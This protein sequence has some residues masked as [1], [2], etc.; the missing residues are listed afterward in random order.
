MSA[1][2]VSL[3]VLLLA[4][5]TPAHVWQPPERAEAYLPAIEAAETAHGLPDGLLARLLYEESR[6]RRDVVAGRTISPRGAVGIAQFMPA[7]ADELGVDPRSPICSI[8]AA[9]RYL[10]WL[11]EHTGTW[12]DAL[13]AYNWGIGRVWRHGRADAPRETRRFVRRI[14]EDVDL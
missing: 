12:R 14:V 4:L 2:A 1:R 5:S 3:L 6:Y 13:A 8:Y 10:A 9:A 7:T 11:H